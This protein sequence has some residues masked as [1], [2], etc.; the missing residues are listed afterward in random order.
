MQLARALRVAVIAFGILAALSATASAQLPTT[1]DPRVGLAPGFENPGVAANGIR[2]LANRP[3][4]PGFSDPANPG[5]FGFLTSDMAFQGDY[6]FV[7]NFNGYHIYNIANPSSPSLTTS[8]ICPGGQGDVSVYKNLLFMSVEESR[9]GSTA[10]PLPA[11]RGH[12][13]PRRSHLRH[14]QHLRARPGGRRSD[15]PRLAHAHAG[16]RQDDPATSTST[17]RAPPPPAGDQDGG[18]RWQQHQ[19]ADG[20]QPVAV[21][22]RGHQGPGGRASE[23]RLVSEPRLLP[24]RRARSTASR[25]RRRPRSTR[26]QRDAAVRAGNRRHLWRHLVADADTDSCH[27]ITVY[28]EIDLAAGA[29]EGNGLLID[30]SDRANPRRIDAVADP[31][32]AYWHGAT[33]SN[34]GKTVVFTDEWGGGVRLAAGRPTTSS[35]AATRSTTSSTAG[36]SSAATTSCRWRRP[37]RRTASAT[38]RR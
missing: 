18:L 29:C 33:F 23:R 37:C 3:K 27:D 28:P 14:Q 22:D 25:T 7:G 15:L 24:T 30:I 1:N 4:P 6:A 35:G 20:H 19:H 11:G 34:D 5:N 32:Y 9:A 10:G 2:H 31:N 26:R 38:S 21:A 8:V 12:A 17:S 36:W 16:D 13:L